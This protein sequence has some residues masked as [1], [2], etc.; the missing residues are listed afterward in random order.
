MPHAARLSCVPVTL[1]RVM[2]M[3]NWV[4]WKC[5]KALVDIPLPLA[6][7][8]ECP[9]CR[10]DLH[11]CRACLYFDPGV[12]RSCREPVAEDVQDKTRA[13]FC[14]YFQ[15]RTDA[16]VPGAA[17][18]SAAARAQLDA[19]FGGAAADANGPGSAGQGGAVERA[20]SALDDLFGGK[21]DKDLDGQG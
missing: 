11:V 9:A 19:L 1:R 8:A 10:S 20:R 17:D 18:T 12:A 16:Y 15:L 6:R 7:A 3:D 21:A 4:C 5:G 14:G 2:V 13:N